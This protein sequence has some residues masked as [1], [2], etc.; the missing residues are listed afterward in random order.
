MSKQ[1]DT[2]MYDE[3]TLQIERLV[4]VLL[5]KGM[6]NISIR[7][8]KT[9]DRYNREHILSLEVSAK[10]SFIIGTCKGE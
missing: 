7:E 5:G 10:M 1:T 6:T 2:N 4:G 9:W 8:K 3:S